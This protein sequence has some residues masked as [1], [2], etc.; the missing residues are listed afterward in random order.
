MGSHDRSIPVVIDVEALIWAENWKPRAMVAREK[1]LASRSSSLEKI[2]EFIVSHRPFGSP[3]SRRTAHF[4]LLPLPLFHPLW[5]FYGRDC[6]H[7]S[8]DTIMPVLTFISHRWWEEKRE[9]RC[10]SKLRLRLYSLC[11]VRNVPGRKYT[12]INTQ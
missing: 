4:M 8:A 12:N 7:K 3:V 1:G 11:R 5:F 9:T 6:V 2:T 10:A